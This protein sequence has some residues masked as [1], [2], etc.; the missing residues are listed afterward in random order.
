MIERAGFLERRFQRAFEV[1]SVQPLSAIACS[2]SSMA[3]Q[4]IL[5]FGLSG[6]RSAL[7]PATAFFLGPRTDILHR[8]GAGGAGAVAAPGHRLIRRRQN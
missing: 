3:S 5:S 8:S 1:S 7:K 6:A 4:D 2:V